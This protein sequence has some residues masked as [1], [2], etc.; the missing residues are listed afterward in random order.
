[1]KRINVNILK[2]KQHKKKNIAKQ[3]DVTAEFARWLR[4]L[5][6]VS[7]SSKL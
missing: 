4:R 5:L 7:S 6:G 1:M 2:L 3:S